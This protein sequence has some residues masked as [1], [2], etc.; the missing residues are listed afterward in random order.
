M[1][2][3]FMV[4]AGIG[5]IMADSTAQPLTIYVDAGSEAG[6]PAD[7]TEAKPYKT[8]QAAI[9]AANGA[10]DA[11]SVTILVAAGTYKGTVDYTPGKPA[12]S[13]PSTTAETE[14][15]GSLG[16]ITRGNVIIEPA[17]GAVAILQ[18]TLTVRAEGVTINGFTFKNA[19]AG[20]IFYQKNSINVF[21]NSIKVRGNKFEGMEIEGISN[22]NST[23]NGVVLYPQ[24]P[25]EELQSDATGVE[26]NYMIESNNFDFNVEGSSAIILREN[27]YSKTQFGTGCAS[28]E[29]GAKAYPITATLSNGAD[30]DKAVVNGE[31]TF[32]ETVG[33]EYLRM[34]GDWSAVDGREA[35]GDDTRTQTWQ[36]GLIKSGATLNKALGRMSAE[37]TLLLENG[38]Y[39]E[40]QT[41]FGPLKAE[42]VTIDAADAAN[43]D[44][45]LNGT[46]AVEAENATIQN[47]K[48]VYSW[49]SAKY[50]DK[51]GISVFA[52]NATI[53][54]NTFTT[55]AGDHG[56]NGVV[57]YPKKSEGSAVTVSYVVEGNTFDLQKAGSTA[58]VVR[59]NF[60][61]KSQIDGKEQTAASLSNGSDL[62]AAIIA[63]NNK[64]SETFAGEYYAR[65]T[66]NYSELDANSSGS[67]AITQKYLYKW[68]TKGNLKESVAY[69]KENATI[70]ADALTMD[71]AMAEMNNT[72]GEAI[73]SLATG[74][75]IL[76]KDAELYTS[77]QTN[78]DA[79]K[80]IAYMTKV[81]EQDAY[82]LNFP[83]AATYY[84]AANG[85]GNG[86]SEAKPLAGKYLQA[87]IKAATA[88]VK[89]AAGT[90]TGNF[91]MKAGVDVTGAVDGNGKPATTLDGDA[92]GRV[93]SYKADA[94]YDGSATSVSDAFASA[95]IWS[96]LIITNGKT[97]DG[98]AG[99]YICANV[100]L[101]NC[102]IT[103][104]VAGTAETASKAGGVLCDFGGILN[105]C[106]VSDNTVYGSGAGIQLNT[107]GSVLN[108]DVFG[109]KAIGAT[110]AV[111]HSGGIGTRYK[112]AN[113]AMLIQNC[114]IY[115]NEAV[116]A[117][118][119]TVNAG[120]T[121]VNTLVYGNKMTGSN[122]EAA[123][124]F[125]NNDKMATMLNC[126]VWGN[127]AAEGV[128]V[129]VSIT[130]ANGSNQ[131]ITNCIMET[132][133]T[134]SKGQFTYNASSSDNLTVSAE[135]H[136]VTLESSPFEADSYEL[137][138][139][140]NDKTNPCING[141]S[142]AAYT[143]TYPKTDLAGKTRIQGFTAP[144][145]V[146]TIDIGAFEFVKVTEPV[147]DADGLADAV[148]GNEP[149]IVLSGDVELGEETLT[150]SATTVIKAQEGAT[151][152][153]T[154]TV[155]EGKTAFATA[156]GAEL[157]L[158]NIQIV[159]EEGASQ[160]T[161]AIE[162]AQNSTVNLE[163]AYIEG[164]TVEV[165]GELNLTN[166]GFKADATTAALDIKGTG[167]VVIEGAEFVGKA[168]TATNGA[169]FT[170]SGCNFVN[171]LTKASTAGALSEVIAAGEATATIDRCKFVGIVGEG[172][173]ISGKKVTV[174]NCLFYNNGNMK[175]MD[176][177]ESST[178][179]IINNTFVNTT[180]VD[181]AKPV[182]T[183]AATQ[184]NVKIKNNI[185]WT[186]ADEA[187][188]NNAAN[189]VVISHNAL[190]T[191]ATAEVLNSVNSL[192]LSNLDDLR[193]SQAEIP[194]QLIDK[195]LVARA[196]GDIEGIADEA[197]DILGAD[198]LTIVGQNKTVHL[199][200]YESVYTPSTG[201]GS[202]GGGTGDTTPDATGIKLDKTTLTL[203]RL[204]S[205]TLIATVEP[206]AAGGVKWT[207]TDPSVATV[208]A[209]GKVTA[210]KVGQATIIATA[211]NGG[212]TALCQVTVDFA[213]GVEEALA[214][215]AI[216]GREG[217]IQIQPATP[218][219]MLIVNMAG[220]VV[221][222]RT[223]SQAETISVPKGIYIV[224]LSRGGHVLTQKVNVR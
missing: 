59:E 23:C 54:G 83:A 93:V 24:K 15:F 118:G 42:G 147:N 205:Y 22:K 63:A 102:V 157:T 1:L 189:N 200:A 75:K 151:E 183:I 164:A 185:L 27:Y 201:G 20:D 125:G 170:L 79:T 31:N 219:E 176:I 121:M 50:S 11:S 13:Q 178:V 169:T 199:G 158:E 98:G 46:L 124:S 119:A 57:F 123:V 49:K 150:V 48:F 62:D 2:A 186:V 43:A 192:A 221:A 85:A 47:L 38:E 86:L 223:I 103:K 160:E 61:S 3:A 161:K 91:V 191:A 16:V 217:G 131:T 67:D 52:D 133:G 165:S 87:A 26:T 109:N 97:N 135:N 179:S 129:N 149:E 146:A 5:W 45:T 137:V 39:G 216:F 214:E 162:V 36:F 69:A 140:I 70:K 113:A 159:V 139:K 156:E 153:I 145:E 28:T 66:G 56:T 203:A 9:E 10:A 182:I 105:G 138:A 128:E 111:A 198:R 171:V 167:V 60:Q 204:Q 33:E 117:A 120:T 19:H 132:I 152:P 29:N 34:T 115:N 17:N 188:E 180:D 95:T 71:E 194:Y 12:E 136:N 134:L 99:A 210:V 74:V 84:V 58:I 77:T 213:T 101:K 90:Y 122:G 44:V 89:L 8:L 14:T 114:K 65:V 148:K 73:T 175:L 55:A 142:N 106:I 196:L 130:D 35:S 154:I 144:Q 100:T 126:T 168:I 224:R 209:N 208:D 218:V 220:T 72:E 195:S 64:F 32:A 7:G 143:E 104:N 25:V 110:A 92:K 112:E 206:A 82:I 88:E 96:N 141:G 207:S 184:T 187:I 76:C 21:A 174:S 193:S 41:A 68:T 30:Q 222:H 215:S 37:G 173:I 51:I 53:K 177:A 40:T 4:L 172:A 155:Q 197:K 211:I 108:C 18:G 127:I 6:D 116:S 78:T 94:A 166:S 80:M 163:G 212:L 81:S 190:K 202:T 181:N 107:N